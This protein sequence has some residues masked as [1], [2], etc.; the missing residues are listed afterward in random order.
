MRRSNG[1]PSGPSRRDVLPTPPIPTEISA[2]RK[3]TI[4]D[5][6]RDDF[7][8]IRVS[9]GKGSAMQEAARRLGMKDVSLASWLR[10]QEKHANA[11]KPNFVPD[12]DIWRPSA[13][14]AR[15][16][17]AA[18]VRRYLLTAAQDN[19]E[20]HAGFWKNLHA[21]A[22]HLAA[23][24]MVG[25]F[26]YQKGLF[27]DH[28]ARSAVFAERR[29]AVPAA[30]AGRPRPGPVLRRDEHPADRGAP[31]VR[32]GE[33]HRAE[34]GCF[35]ARQ[36]AARQRADLH[37]FARQADLMT[38]GACTIANYVAK[39]AGLKAEFH[40]V[41]G[42]TLVE[43]DDR[44]RVWCRQINATADGA[45]QDLDLV[46]KAGKVSPGHRVEAVTH[47]DIHREKLDPLVAMGTWGLDLA[48]EKVVSGDSLVD[49]LRPRYQFFHDLLDFEARNHHRIKDHH[50]RLQ[51]LCQGSD[52]VEDAVASCARFLRQTERVWSRSVIVFSNHDDALAKWLKTADYK[53]DAANA[54]FFL[55]CDLA[56]HEAIEAGEARFNVFR[57][58]LG[59]ADARELDGI[60]FV[61]DDASFVICQAAGGVECG[62]HGHLGINGA[63]GSPASFTKTAVKMN[64]GHTHSPGILDGVYTAGLS[65]LMD[66]GY[67]RGLSSWEQA[68]V[69]TYPSGKRTLITLRD[70]RWR[71]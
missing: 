30:R 59:R 8:P 1:R 26:T 19:T 71:A 52:R 24:V 23:E 11:G 41:I 68:H 50:F 16:T 65:G 7:A 70:G 28:A 46:V 60:D 40:H 6:M 66:Q 2:L 58:A 10:T 35:P 64:T 53:L 27:E 38:T 29:A 20:V 21:Y 33:L 37:R 36:G 67:N 9:G 4:E 56:M 17:P 57:W 45:F 51:M 48:T 61:D 69:V 63:R 43:I 22:A 12:W 62:M 49:A 54:R 31:A 25:G 13:T 18:T 15:V 39:K 44:D 34:M 3:Q 55:A 42:A 47:G 14:A 32:P 5:C